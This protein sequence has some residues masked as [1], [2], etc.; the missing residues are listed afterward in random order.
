MPVVVDTVAV[1]EVAM[2]VVEVETGEGE[3][4]A[5]VVLPDEEAAPAAVVSS[6]AQGSTLVV[7]EVMAVVTAVLAPADEIMEMDGPP[8]T[9]EEVEETAG[10]TEDGRTVVLVEMSEA[11]A[12]GSTEVVADVAE[13]ED[14]EKPGEVVATTDD[15]LADVVIAVAD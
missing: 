12:Q 15:D 7:G 13:D 14:E 8:I 11:P 2:T 6:S 3:E 9:A 4:T 10:A 1:D 5:G